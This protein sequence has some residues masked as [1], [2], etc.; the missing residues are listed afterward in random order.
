[1]S[2]TPAFEYTHTVGCYALGEFGFSNPVDVALDRD[3]IL[4]V[5]SRGN[6][7]FEENRSTKRVTVC[8]VG[9]EFLGEFATGGTGDGDIMWP[10]SIAVD[11]DG[12][13]Y[14]S[15][16]ALDRIS[17]FSKDGEFMAKWGTRGSG[18]GEFGRPSGIAFDGEGN[19][20]VADGLNSRIQRWTREGRFLGSWGNEGTGDGEFNMPWGI[21]VDSEGNVYVADWRNDR[22]QKLDPEGKHLATFGSPGHG[23]GGFHRPAGVAVDRDGNVYV[24]DWGNERVQVLGP[25]GDFIAKLRGQSVYSK[26]AQNWFLSNQ[27]LLDERDRSDLHPP[28]HATPWGSFLRDE[29]ANVES[30]LWGPTAVKVGADG[31]LFIVDSLRHRIQVYERQGVRSAASE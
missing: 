15:D 19:L 8:N 4:Y 13:V 23:D 5:V 1:M 3:G 25:G 9:G 2:A 11:G 16:E 21:S 30:L 20:L 12:N 10:A 29:S 27:D 14:I 22:V 17:V 7:D 24:A 26:W 28:V 18:D 6:L 31:S